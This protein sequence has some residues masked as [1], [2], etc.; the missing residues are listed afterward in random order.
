MAERYVFLTNLASPLPVD[1]K[2]PPLLALPPPPPI[3][4]LPV[5]TPG[6]VD[7]AVKTPH[8]TP[9]HCHY[10]SNLMLISF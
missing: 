1:W 5:E 9:Q 4:P 8:A 2:H 10:I 3:P 7:V 6:L